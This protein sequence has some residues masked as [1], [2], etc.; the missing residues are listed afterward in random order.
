LGITIA[1]GVPGTGQV[2]TVTATGR[3]GSSI[4]SS[5][6][7]LSVPVGTSAGAQFTGAVTLSATGGRDVI[8]S[9]ACSS[10]GKK[11]K[12]CAFTPTGPSAVT[13]NVQ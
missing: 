6:A 2:V 3:S 12:T 7:G 13:A 10:S 5:P 9:G 11:A 8:W 1:P 4:V